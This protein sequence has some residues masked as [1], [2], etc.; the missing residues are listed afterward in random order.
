MTTEATTP[1]APDYDAIVRVVQLYL[2]GFND[3]SVAKFKEAFHENAWIF[4]SD[5]E[6]VLH[7]YLLLDCFEDWAAPHEGKIVGRF[8]SVI[9]AGDVAVVVLGFDHSVGTSHSWVDIHSLLRLDGVW[10][11]MNKTAT[12]NSRAAWA[13]AG[14]SPP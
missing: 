12:H 11:I 13:G 10:K 14:Y 4:F 6:G 1:T 3:C 2:D 9:Q 8:L 5:D 7:K